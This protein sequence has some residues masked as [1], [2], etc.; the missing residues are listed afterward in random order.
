MRIFG[1][2]VVWIGNGVCVLSLVSICMMFCL[3]LRLVKEMLL[4][5]LVVIV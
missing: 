5:L 4:I 3:R 2:V 1:I